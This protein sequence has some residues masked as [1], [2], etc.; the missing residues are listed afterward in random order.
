MVIRFFC[1]SF[2]V[3]KHE[4]IQFIHIECKVLNGSNREND[5][6]N[7]NKVERQVGN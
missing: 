6:K 2:G 1:V 5:F 3:L 7:D 4:L